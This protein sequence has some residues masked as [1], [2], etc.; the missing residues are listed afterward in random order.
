M[1]D[2]KDKVMKITVKKHSCQDYTMSYMG[3]ERLL[4]WRYIGYSKREAIQKFKEYVKKN[5]N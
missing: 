4:W 5:E 1:K 2:K 3:K